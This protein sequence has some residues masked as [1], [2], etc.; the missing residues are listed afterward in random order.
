MPITDHADLARH[1]SS[2][3]VKASPPVALILTTLAGIPW[4]TIVYVLTALYL[5]VQTCYGIW[6]WRR[7]ALTKP[8]KPTVPQDR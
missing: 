6:K 1:V 8:P 3:A 5:I 2:T 4:Q 7:E